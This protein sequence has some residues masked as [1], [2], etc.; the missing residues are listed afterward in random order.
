MNIRDY[1]SYIFNKNKLKKIRLLISDIDGVMTDGRLIID[2]NGIE[3]KFF[4]T[5]D[6]TGI[7]MALKSEIKI[8]V[9]SGSS[10]SSIKAR[11]D[12]FRKYGFEDLILGKENKMPSVLTLI[13]KYGLNKEEIAYIGDDLIDLKVMR[14]AGISFAP[15]DAHYEA[16]KTADIIINKKGGH[17]AFRAAVDMILKS[18]GIYSEVI[19]RF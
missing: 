18:K 9:I 8:S 5:Q 1:I 11:F 16:L 17:G 13:E 2:D 3:S 12:K 19:K 14:Y 4:H 15:K 10:S 6:G 7:I